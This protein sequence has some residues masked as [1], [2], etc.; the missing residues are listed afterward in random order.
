MLKD[1]VFEKKALETLLRVKQEPVSRTTLTGAGGGKRLST[2]V[3]YGRELAQRPELI[4]LLTRWRKENQHGF[5]KVFDVTEESTARWCRT[6]LIER[7]DRLLYLVQDAQARFVAHVGV[8]S[9]DFE[10]GTC[11]VDNI[12]RGE[13]EAPK[14]IMAS[15]LVIL[16]DWIYTTLAP[17]QIQLRTFNDNSRALALYHRLGFVPFRLD[18]LH[19]I[20]GEGNA[21]EWVP[22]LPD[23]RYDRFFIAMRHIRSK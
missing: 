9:F 11:E 14:G 18:A 10:A 3:P 2:L 13:P 23:M 4:P 8:S 6:Q 22:A 20:R 15:A 16:M 5:A 21:V 12:V 1:T 17:R 7:P 19:E